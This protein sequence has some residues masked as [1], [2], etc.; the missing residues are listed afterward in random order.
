MQFSIYKSF[1]Q[2]ADVRPF[3]KIGVQFC[4]LM[5]SESKMPVQKCKK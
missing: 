4:L 5:F 3:V 2:V 1:L